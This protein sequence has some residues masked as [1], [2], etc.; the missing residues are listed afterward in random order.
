MA[1]GPG[2]YDD[3]CT[4]VRE[5]TNA[6]AVVIIVGSGTRGSGFSI[7]L[8]ADHPAG[9]KRILEA[10]VESLRGCADQVEKDAAKL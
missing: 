2:I 10:I 7:Q 5:L 4:V 6:E 9:T 1:V 8:N 3:I